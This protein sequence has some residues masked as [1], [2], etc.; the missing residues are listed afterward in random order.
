LLLLGLTLTGF[1]DNLVSDTGQPSNHDPK[2]I[3]HGLLCGAWMIVLVMQSSLVSV[4]NVRLHR[5]LGI[6]AI[7]IAI[8]VTLSTVWLFVVL[9]KGWA[10]MAPEVKAN[11]LLLPG[12]SL[13]VALGFLNRNRPQW[14]KRF[15]YTGTLLMLEPVLAR[16]FDPLLVP[17]MGSLTEPQIEAAFLPSLFS[18]WI[19][20][21][22]SLFVYDIAVARRL[23]PVTVAAL[24]WFGGVWTTAL[25]V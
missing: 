19:G 17:F 18:I 10:A 24:L 13:F 16:A 9:W 2:F 1:W 21:F 5:R 20:F 14:H 23:H 6:A 11:R 4:G 7:I 3:I 12:Y 15:I 22:L 25:A 8:G